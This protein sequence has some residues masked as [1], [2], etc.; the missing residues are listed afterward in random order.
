[1]I[2]KR[3]KLPGVQKLKKNTILWSLFLANSNNSRNLLHTSLI[4]ILFDNK[5]KYKSLNLFKKIYN[6]I[7]IKKFLIFHIS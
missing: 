7:K 6:I 4:L 5:K 2:K 3:K 1:M